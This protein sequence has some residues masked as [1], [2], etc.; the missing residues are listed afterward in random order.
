MEYRR[1]RISQDYRDGT[2]QYD[3]DMS[4]RREW[5]ESLSPSLAPQRVVLESFLATAARDERIRVVVVGCSL[6][7][8]V[9]DALSDVDALIGVRPEAWKSVIADSR[10]WVSD[11]GPVIDMHQMTLPGSAGSA[12]DHQ[13]T[14]AQYASGVELDLSVSPVGDDWRRRADWIVLYD[15]DSRVPSEVTP[16]TQTADDIRRWGYGALTRL[17]AVVKYVSRGALWEALTCLELARADTWRVWAVAEQVA[18]AQYGVTAVFDDPREPIPPA[19][20]RTVASLDARSLAA[21]ARACCEVVIEAWPDAMR[22]VGAP[23]KVPPLAE[24]VRRR[25]SNLAAR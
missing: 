17:N 24:Y 4:A 13:H 14:Y 5:L 16:L 3:S 10:Q 25:L 6:G 7:R 20:A 11:A 23:Q 22:A 1:G 12:R 2:G 21:G 9:G 19:M 15:P 18:D 8:N